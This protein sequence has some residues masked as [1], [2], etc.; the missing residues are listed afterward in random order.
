MAD[1][2]P[3][4]RSH[5]G[6][7]R[8]NNFSIPPYDSCHAGT[9]TS[10][11]VDLEHFMHHARRSCV[12]VDDVQLAARKNPRTREAIEAEAVRMRE[13]KKDEAESRGVKRGRP[14]GRGAPK[15]P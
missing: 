2:P 13:N 15:H 4:H 3:S 6:P 1:A 8:S 12:N 5:S 14:A 11:A 9:T 10:L 7:A